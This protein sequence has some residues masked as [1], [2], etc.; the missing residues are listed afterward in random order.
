MDNE[1]TFEVHG[2][3]D[4]PVSNLLEK[5]RYEFEVTEVSNFT[6][7]KGNRCA[8]LSLAIEG[9]KIT[10]ILLLEGKMEWKWRQFL[11][12]IGIRDRRT[13]FSVGRSA[14]VGKKGLVDVGVRDRVME[15]GV[16]VK[17]NTIRS[18]SPIQSPSAP[19]AG[20]EPEDSPPKETP[21]E[22]PKEKK[23]EKEKK[24]DK[25]VLQPE[26]K[27]KE[28]ETAKTDDGEIDIDDL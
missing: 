12:A 10:D 13:D 28:K 19:V 5:R 4:L 17:D 16:I 11:F 9:K 23:K 2:S 6:S 3:T 22:T 8:K 26:E 25:P 15:D 20:V 18:Y 1:E 27:P 21:K 7:A 14:I 24:E